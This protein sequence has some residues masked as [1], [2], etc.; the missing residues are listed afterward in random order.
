MDIVIEFWQ[1]KSGS[2]CNPCK[3][4]SGVVMRKDSSKCIVRGVSLDCDLSVWDPWVR[5]GA[6]VKAFKCFKAE[7][8]SSEKCPGV[9]LWVDA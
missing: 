9:P 4:P 6:V 5:T 3:L 8:H 7:W 2:G 1:K